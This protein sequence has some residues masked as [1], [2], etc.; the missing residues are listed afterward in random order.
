MLA[1]GFQ[2][3]WTEQRL[4]YLRL[5]SATV[6]GGGRGGQN[7]DDDRIYVY[8]CCTLYN[9]ALGGSHNGR[10]LYNLC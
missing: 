1:G 9:N 5:P 4:R 10:L 2:R 6:K 7:A 3:S 8:Y